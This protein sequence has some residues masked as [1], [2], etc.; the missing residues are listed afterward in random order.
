MYNAFATQDTE[1][2]K[3]STRLHMDMAD[4]VN[5]MVYAEQCSDGSL[6]GARWDL[7]R[8]EDAPAI[9]QFLSERFKL[10][11]GLDPIH[12]QQ[13]YLD[14]RLRADLFAKTGVKSHCVIQRQGEA[15]FIPAGCAHQVRTIYY[16]SRNTSLKMTIGVQS[17]RLHQGRSRLCEPR[18][19]RAMCSFDRR[20]P[21]AKLRTHVE[22]GRAAIA[23]DDVV[24]MGVM[25]APRGNAQCIVGCTSDVYSRVWH[26]AV[27]VHVDAIWLCMYSHFIAHRDTAITC[28]LHRVT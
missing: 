12:S 26:E 2:S 22:G 17:L 5:V 8:A 24:C 13:F 6:G 10:A 21:C 14:E 25:L 20:V 19:H 4:A 7:Y 11:S 15:V 23:D 1:G 3:G 18:E 16:S 27:S 28:I 9:R